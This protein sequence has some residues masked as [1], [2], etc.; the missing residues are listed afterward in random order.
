[1]GQIG[2]LP[3]SNLAARLIPGATFPETDALPDLIDGEPAY[4]IYPVAFRFHHT[5]PDPERVKD[6]EPT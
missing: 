4:P 6:Y 1:V 3:V 5:I 2:R